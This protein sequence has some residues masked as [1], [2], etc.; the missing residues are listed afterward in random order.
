LVPRRSLFTWTPKATPSTTSKHTLHRTP[1]QRL[2]LLALAPEVHDIMERG[3]LLMGGALLLAQLP[4]ARQ[5]E[6]A[7]RL[8]RFLALPQPVTSERLSA[9][10]NGS[11]YARPTLGDS[12]RRAL[13]AFYAPHAPELRALW[14][15]L[16]GGA[17]HWSGA[18]WLQPIAASVATKVAAQRRARVDTA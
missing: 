18:R 10:V 16:E 13:S 1:Y 3:H 12:M 8:T 7:E 15:E 2:R 5:S 4:V 6:V 14:R 17:G 9:I 11:R